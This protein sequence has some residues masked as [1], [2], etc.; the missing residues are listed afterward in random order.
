MVHTM[1]LKIA[2]LVALSPISF[3]NADDVPSNSL[4][5]EYQN[6]EIALSDKLNIDTLYHIPA[7]TYRYLDEVFTNF[8]NK[9]TFKT[10]IADSTFKNSE[11]YQLVAIPLIAQNKEG[12]QFELFG[13][14]SDPATQSLSNISADQALYHYYSS[15]EQLDLYNSSLS[16]GAG[17][18]FNTSE[19]SKVKVIISNTEIPGYGTSNALVGFETRF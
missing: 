16:I 19:F 1:A 17:F 4:Q 7:V 6:L 8:Y 9:V 10:T 18:S 5:V 15:T 11:H 2:V 14:F 3:C 13:H 12:V